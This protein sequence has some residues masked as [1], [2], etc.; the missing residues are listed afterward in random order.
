MYAA[1]G[2]VLRQQ[3]VDDP[4]GRA[5]QGDILDEDAV[6]LVEV[7]HLRA[8][9][10]LGTEAT[11]VHVD[12]VFGLLQQTGAGSHVLGDAALLH[13]E[14]LVATPG[15]P[16][17]VGAATVDGAA[18]RDGDI[19]GLIGIDERTEVPA[20]QAL[21]AGGHDGVELRLEGKLQYGAFLDDEVDTRLQLD[22]SGK[23]LLASRHHDTAATLGRAL[24]DGLLDGLLVFCCGGCRLCPILGDV[25]HGVCK[26]RHA[27]ALLNLLVLL[28]V[29]SLCL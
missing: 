6:A 3:R 5:Q 27:D 9:T 21:P 13:A 15:P 17:L 18:P 4:E 22:G 24:V 26:L 2:D 10:V 8:Q 1:H 7:D 23:K 28:G 16:C 29:P 19:L 20:V 14:P 25:V 11:L 12:T